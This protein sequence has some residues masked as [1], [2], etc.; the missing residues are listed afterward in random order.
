MKISATFKDMTTVNEVLRGKFR[1]INVCLK[2][3]RSQ[4]KV[5]EKKINSKPTAKRGRML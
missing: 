5:L 3:K 1:A 4:L 2:S